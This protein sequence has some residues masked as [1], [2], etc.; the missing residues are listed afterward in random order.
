[1]FLGWS[2][3]IV[4]FCCTEGYYKMGVDKLT[5][6][7]LKRLLDFIETSTSEQ[8]TPKTIHP[9]YQHSPTHCSSSNNTPPK[10]THQT[11]LQGRVN[12]IQMIIVTTELCM[13]KKSLN[14]PTFFRILIYYWM[15]CRYHYF[16]FSLSFPSI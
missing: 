12:N 7:K 9:T 2:S 14:S 10:I 3:K 4:K 16:F 13:R 11:I 6:R 1:M 5:Q 8:P 15:I